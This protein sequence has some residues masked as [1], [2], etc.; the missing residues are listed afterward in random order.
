[1]LFKT[2]FAVLNRLRQS[3]QVVQGGGGPPPPPLLR[4]PPH[5]AGGLVGN[6]VRERAGQR[7]VHLRG[8]Q[9]GRRGQGIHHAHGGR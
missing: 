2:A 3:V 1:M 7:P 6:A 5:A 9:H 8:Q 4:T